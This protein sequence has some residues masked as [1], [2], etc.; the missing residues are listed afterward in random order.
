MCTAAHFSNVSLCQMSRVSLQ[1]CGILLNE[2]SH[3]WITHLAAIQWSIFVYVLYTFRTRFSLLFL[4][5]LFFFLLFSSIHLSFTTTCGY[6]ICNRKFCSADEKYDHDDDDDEAVENA[7][8]K[9]IWYFACKM[10]V[11]GSDL[12]RNKINNCSFCFDSK[13][14]LFIRLY[15]RIFIVHW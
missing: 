11:I 12:T 2:R 5:F 9:W 1:V 14:R 7:S 10:H 13:L 3:E 6:N 8:G 15:F 4:S